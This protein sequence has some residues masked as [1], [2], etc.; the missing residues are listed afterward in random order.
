M[1]RL[2]KPSDTEAFP[3]GT[4]AAVRHILQTRHGMPP[5][6]RDLNDLP[7]SQRRNR[8]RLI[9]QLPQDVVGIGAAFGRGAHQAARGPAEAERLADNRRRA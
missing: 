9:A 6:S 7:R 2:P 1:P 3:E 4:R 8:V 5:P